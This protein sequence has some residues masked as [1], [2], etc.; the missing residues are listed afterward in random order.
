MKGVGFTDHYIAVFGIK[1][2]SVQVQNV[3]P[4][5]CPKSNTSPAFCKGCQIVFT[6]VMFSKQN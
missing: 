5:H 1:L 6:T 4:V 3:S 2:M